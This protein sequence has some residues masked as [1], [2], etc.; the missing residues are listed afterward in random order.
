M[1]ARRQVREGFLSLDAVKH[2]RVQNNS[3]VNKSKVD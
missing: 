3:Q 1:G 2:M